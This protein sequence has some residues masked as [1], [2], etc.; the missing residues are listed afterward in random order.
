M[1]RSFK[2]KALS[3]LA[4]FSVLISAGLTAAPS[5]AAGPVADPVT[6]ISGA[7]A[8]DVSPAAYQWT[9]FETNMKSESHCNSLMGKMKPAYGPEWVWR[10]GWYYAN[11]CPQEIRWELQ[12]A[13][14]NGANSVPDSPVTLLAQP[15]VLA[16]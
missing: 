16:C 12:M 11:M 2:S 8:S 6:A 15:M 13:H 9:T 4:V 1:R 7:A 5:F 10:C 3:A 14:R